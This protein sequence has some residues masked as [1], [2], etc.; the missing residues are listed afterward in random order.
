MGDHQGRIQ[1]SLQ[2][3]RQ[4]SKISE[5]LHEIENILGGRGVCTLG[6]PPLDPPLITMYRLWT[7]RCR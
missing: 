1:D 2:E 5:K 7:R 3:G 4:P 6:A